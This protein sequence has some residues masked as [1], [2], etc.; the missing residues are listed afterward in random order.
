MRTLVRSVGRASLGGEPLPSPFKAF[1]NNQIIIRRAEVSMFAGA[2]GAG[3]ST[4][5]LALAL[6]MKV[7]T[8]YISAD[9]NAHTMAMSLVSSENTWCFLASLIFILTSSGITRPF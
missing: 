5:A 4:L 8:L 7:P 9:T 2:P 3:K 6:K 1:E